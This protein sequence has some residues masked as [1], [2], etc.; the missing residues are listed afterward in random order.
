MRTWGWPGAT[1]RRTRGQMACAG[2]RMGEAPR[3]PGAPKSSVVGEYNPLPCFPDTRASR[4][5]TVHRRRL[6]R[7]LRISQAG[8]ERFRAGRRRRACV[9]R[10]L[11]TGRVR[12]RGRGDSSLCECAR[13]RFAADYPDRQTDTRKCR[14]S[15]TAAL[16]LLRAPHYV[17][18]DRS[19]PRSGLS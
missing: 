7:T 11:P 6:A 3:R 5:K 18:Y 19:A 1:Q 4:A 14:K 13:W 15:D 17:A 16:T 10:A 2:Q 12:R 8:E 9:D